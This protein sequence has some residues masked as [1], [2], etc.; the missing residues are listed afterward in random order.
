[1]MKFIHTAD[2]HLKRIFKNI[3][4]DKNLR[5]E[6]QWKCLEKIIEASNEVDFLM[7]SGDLY[8]REYFTLSDIHRLLEAF[9]NTK[10]RIIIALGNHDHYKEDSVFK[11]IKLPENVFVFPPYKKYFQFDEF[12]LRIYGF[13]WEKDLYK[14]YD[15]NFDLDKNYNNI[16]VMHGTVDGLD[17]YLPI[18]IEKIRDFDYVAL[19]HIH[20]F[21]KINEKIFYPGSPEGLS[22][23]ETGPRYYIYGNLKD[24]TLTT[25]QVECQ[26]KKLENYKV[27]ISEKNINEILE[28][29]SGLN[30]DTI[31]RLELLGKNSE[32][33]FYIKTI[34]SRF[35]FEI[36]DKTEKYYEI[37]KL[38]E[39]NKN[40]YIE[41]V[42]KDLKN[43]QSPYKDKALDLAVKLLLGD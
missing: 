18:N 11:N 36:I 34:K 8:E 28:E 27:D 32:K 17:D 22:F 1:M 37:D 21:M 9:K 10:A 15:L 16:L 20:K 24:K 38:I 12:N 39:E 19:G 43:S 7:I 33:D 6:D 31:Y 5:R 4:I 23:K 29:L 42:F 14:D 13:S 25:K 41:N 40:T 35:D 26:I 2:L 3:N 30:K